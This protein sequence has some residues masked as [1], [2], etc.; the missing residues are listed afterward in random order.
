MKKI[1]ADRNYRLLKNAEPKVVM[2]KGRATEKYPEGEHPAVE[3]AKISTKDL[4][5]AKSVASSILYKWKEKNKPTASIIMVKLSPD[6]KYQVLY[7]QE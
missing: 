5:H 4:Q 2:H 6:R 1:A 3:L 7:L